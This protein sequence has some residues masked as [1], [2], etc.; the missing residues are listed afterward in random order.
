MEIYLDEKI[1]N[2]DLFT[3]RKNEL[4]SLLKWVDM[5]KP[6]LAKS[7]AMLSR[8][9]TGK[10]AI[11]HRL[12]NIVFN[13]NDGVI[14][15]Y[16]EIHE[17]DQWIVTF[18]QDFFLTFIFQ[19]ITFKT[20]KKHYLMSGLMSFNLAADIAQKENLNYLIDYIRF[21]QNQVKE[22][23]I[24]VWNTV[25][26]MP[27]SIAN[28]R[29]ERIAQFIDEFQ[30]FNRYIYRDKNCTQRLD[31][32][33]GSYFHTAE[34]KSAPLLITGSWVGW[35]I[36]DLSKMLHGRF[37]KDYY[38]DNLPEDEAIEAIFKYSKILDVPITNEIAQLMLELTEGNPFY[39]SALFYSSYPKKD[40]T[41]EDGLRETLEH[42]VLFKGG[43]IKAQWMEYLSYAFREINGTDHNLSKN[44]VLYLCQNKDREVTRDEIRKKFKLKMPD[45][46]LE[47]RM[48]A[49][50]ESDIINP[51]RSLY[52]YQGIRDHIF[53]KVFRGNYG[54]EIA[55]FN[56]KDITNE[57][58]M[59]F[60]KWKEKFHVI[61]GKYGNL[62]GRF[63]EYMITNHL[64][65]RAFNNNDLF[66]SMMNNL[67]DDFCFVEYQ[68]VWK[69]TASPV[70]KKSIEIDIFA[71][72]D[73]DKY[74]LIGEVKNRLT[75][76]SVD[77]AET[78]LNK[79]KDL[80]ALENVKKAMIFVYS[81]KG[82][83]TDAVTFFKKHH[84]A[85]CDDER[86]LDNDIKIL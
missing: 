76:F 47:K 81:I 69:Y 84:M 64:K 31:D 51:G 4:T 27:R 71:R 29:D 44:I 46:E 59:L 22:E 24:S 19:Y 17:Y 58:K 30:Y 67:P 48:T 21:V 37:R 15:F 56:P 9:K 61:C 35:L 54:D 74:S 12:F 72:A 62:K 36:R 34:Y 80:M 28:S 82:F 65:I 57:Y 55:M 83:T 45:Y 41:N 86:W 40:F 14:P 43:E 52:F 7:T 68:T 49:L 16:Y 2:P 11:L 60:E 26:E 66:C 77:E 78:F 75:P 23:D 70:F 20:R 79:A 39:I 3:G 42:E 53:D 38:L 8:R 10:T 32:L 5:I 18:S 85:W 25:R 73:K 50:V 1:G 6:K 33:A 63:A 13:Q